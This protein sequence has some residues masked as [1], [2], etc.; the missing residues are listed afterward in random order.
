MGVSSGIEEFG[1][2]IERRAL[3]TA[4]SACA[5]GNNQ[6]PQIAQLQYMATNRCWFMPVVQHAI[7]KRESGIMRGDYLS[8]CALAHMAQYAL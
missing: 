4:G 8:I 5:C 7:N 2:G 6:G 1:L 3:A